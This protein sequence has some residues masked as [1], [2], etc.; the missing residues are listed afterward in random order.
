[1]A[2]A[3]YVYC[4]VYA[5]RVPRIG[6]V[7][8]GIPGAAPLTVR[9]AGRSLWIAI[10]DVPLEVYGHPALESALKDMNW[11]GRVAI[12]HEQVV[13]RFSRQRG[14]TVIPMKL[15]T[16]FS[17]EKRAV[18][19]TRS[20]ARELTA[21]AKQISGCE[22]WGV[23]ITRLPRAVVRKS[24]ADERPATGA[25]FLAARKQARDSANDAT[26]MAA[27]SAVAAYD[28]LAAL[29]RDVRRRRDIPDG[30]STPPL[31]EAAFLVPASRRSTFKAAA[32]RLAAKGAAAGTE[33][34]LTGPWPAYNFVQPEAAS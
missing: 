22:E 14:C 32:K 26:R 6:R 19:A 10:A 3:T 1:M 20:R 4:I 24:A 16:M 34:T 29:A 30:A 2:T 11:V 15:F 31:I 21:M 27:E 9:G 5:G 25:A 18:E 17:T 13:E 8:G 12:A 23:R 33:L 28:N 7:P